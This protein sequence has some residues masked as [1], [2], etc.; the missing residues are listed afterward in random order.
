MTVF[1]SFGVCFFLYSLC[2]LYVAQLFPNRFAASASES[3]FLSCS[4]DARVSRWGRRLGRQPTTNHTVQPLS[5]ASQVL[6]KFF[7]FPSLNNFTRLIWVPRWPQYPIPFP[8]IVCIFILPNAQPAVVVAE[9][10]LTDVQSQEGRNCHADLTTNENK[11]YQPS[12]CRQR[13]T[14][15][16]L[17]SRKIH[18][19]YTYP[20]TKMHSRGPSIVAEPLHGVIHLVTAPGRYSTEISSHFLVGGSLCCEVMI[21]A[22]PGTCT[23]GL[24]PLKC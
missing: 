22:R 23:K 10:T 12:F 3:S 13:T 2:N 11:E 9:I 1:V 14:R 17:F 4:F 19:F 8:G 18:L 20:V 7:I 5:F 24:M 16:A 15:T 21:S 6:F